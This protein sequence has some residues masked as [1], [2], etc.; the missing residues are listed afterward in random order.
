V[1]RLEPCLRAFLAIQCLG[2]AGAI[3]GPGRVVDRGLALLLVL[4]GISVLLARRRALF[5]AVAGWFAI[6]TLVSGFGGGLFAAALSPFAR[7]IRYLTPLAIAALIVNDETRAQKL[8]R[9]G[10]AAVFAGHGVEALLLNPSFIDYLVVTADRLAELTIPLSLA[11]VLLFA[12]GVADVSLAV[13]LIRRPGRAVLGYMAFW[14]VAT[15]LMRSV[16]FGPELGWPHTLVRV[17]N[18]GAPLMLL[19]AAHQP[20]A[21]QVP[22]ES[23][24]RGTA[25]VT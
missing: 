22:E 17:L 1:R 18:G 4:A 25:P 2:A 11:Q 3:I 7:A 8:L 24:V 10:T 15:A 16:Y 13:I 21:K 5:F 23:S 14:G 6:E 20:A 9:Y 12:I 19:L